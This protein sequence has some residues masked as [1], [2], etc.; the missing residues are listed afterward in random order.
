MK[1]T[2]IFTSFI[3]LVMTVACSAMSE[4]G[5]A[6]GMPGEN[7]PQALGPLPADKGY[8]MVEAKNWEW[9]DKSKE[10]WAWYPSLT[11]DSLG[12]KPEQPDRVNKYGSWADGPLLTATG[13]FYTT[14]YQNRWVIVDP[15]GRIH[16]DA[17]LV[18]INVGAGLVNKEYFTQKYKD[19]K[20]LWIEHV[21]EQLGDYGFNGAG[22][23]SDEDRIRF[24]ND[25]STDRKITYCPN[26]DV[27]SDYAY[28]IGSASHN[29]GN[30]AYPNK[31]SLVFDPG[32]KKYC[33]KVIPE[34]VSI[35]KDDPNVLGYFTDNEMPLQVGNLKGYL[36]LPE[37]DHGRAA[38]E[39][40]L[41]QKGISADQITSEIS[42]EFAGYVADTY[43]RI[44]SKILKE[45][46]PNHM[47]LGARY[48]GISKYIEGVYK[49]AAKYCDIIS[50][51]YYDRWSI[52]DSH[53]DIR[54]WE[55]WADRPFMITEFY[56][57]GEDSYGNLPNITG[58]G[59]T[60][61]T[62]KDRGIHYE[63]FIIEL[64]RSKTCVGWSWL[65]YL[66]NDPTT[67]NAE[68]SNIDSNKGILDN[69]YE[70]YEDLVSSMAKVNRI[71]YGLLSY[72]W[73]YQ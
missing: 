26:I 3:C 1:K 63:N 29:P 69:R 42:R 41:R 44:V 12:V 39:S 50:L 17:A 34:F 56:T 46:D 54:M 8:V 60:V 7:P 15:E 53:K 33:E 22:A 21:A 55:E 2:V 59:W 40:W 61:H 66:D 5:D 9:E 48:A 52:N 6:T 57:K 16:I 37:G 31:C 28:K 13:F 67:P 72:N 20:E 4:D 36:T 47:Y 10:F 27:M 65:K 32:F 58:A 43:F 23:W 71:R 68:A 45:H 35:Y 73:L 51:N 25:F 64:L 18:G 11:V 24:Y 30:T 38:A 19:D 14:K 62:Q 70:P 49:A